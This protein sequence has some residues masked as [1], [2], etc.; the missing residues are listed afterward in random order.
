MLRDN[1]AVTLAGFH[2][3]NRPFLLTCGHVC[4]TR[5]AARSAPDE[6]GVF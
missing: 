1:V 6:R 2:S 5:E 4:A 3:N